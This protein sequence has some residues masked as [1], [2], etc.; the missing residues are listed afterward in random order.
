MGITRW[1]RRNADVSA[2]VTTKK[3][4]TAADLIPRLKVMRDVWSR[5]T[6]TI[7]NDPTVYYTASYGSRFR[8]DRMPKR[9]LKGKKKFGDAFGGGYRGRIKVKPTNR[10]FGLEGSRPYMP[11]LSD[12]WIDGPLIDA[13]ESWWLE[14]DPDG[15]G[16]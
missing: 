16:S 3:D 1:G 8:D 15:D 7:Q 12:K 10:R 11:G 2:T 14:G 13:L 5:L 6:P 9:G 4:P